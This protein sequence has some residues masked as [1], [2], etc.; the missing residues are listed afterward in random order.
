M[1]YRRIEGGVG[2]MKLMKKVLSMTLGSMMAAATLLPAT[3]IMAATPTGKT[4]DDWLTT[5]GTI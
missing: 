2:T 5:K 1:R 3:S 4:G